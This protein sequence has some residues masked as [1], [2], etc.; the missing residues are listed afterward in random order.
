MG[1]SLLLAVA[2][3]L[4]AG[5]RL[6][7][8][9][10]FASVTGEEKGLLGARHLAAHPPARVRHFAANV[11]IDMPLF[12]AR[13]KDVVAF[14][15]EHSSL[16]TVLNSVAARR[17]ILVSPDPLPDETI[18]VRSDQYA[19]VRQGVP[20]IYLNTGQH[21]VDPAVDLVAAEAKFRQERYHKPSDDLAQPIDWAAT[22]PYAAL[23]TDLTREIAD[24]PKAPS[25]LPGD[26]FGELFGKH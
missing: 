12:I 15:S 17:G 26:F 1:T 23:M 13:A 25:W 8:P 6:R 18:F 14:G 3:E 19:F 11:N 16:G 9:V 20:A 21:A 4:A 10:L 22:G 24:N 5:P 7:R 2:E